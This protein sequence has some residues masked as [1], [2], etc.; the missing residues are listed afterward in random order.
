M[1]CTA[2]LAGL[3]CEEIL[4]TLD[5]AGHRTRKKWNDAQPWLG[6]VFGG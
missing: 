1:P 6:H 5:V 3:R 4:S 2:K